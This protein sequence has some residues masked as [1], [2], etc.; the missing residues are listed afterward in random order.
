[1]SLV[2]HHTFVLLGYGSALMNVHGAYASILGLFFAE[3][4]NFPMHFRIILRTY[5]LKFT[6][7]YELME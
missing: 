1:M 2:M 3:I 4:S 5:D 7:L 6:K